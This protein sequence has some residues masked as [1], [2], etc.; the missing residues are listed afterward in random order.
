MSPAAPNLLGASAQ[1]PRLIAHEGEPEWAHVW[2]VTPDGVYQPIAD[3][4]RP[5]RS[6]TGFTQTMPD[7]ALR[8]VCR[9]CLAREAE[10]NEED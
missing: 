6:V 1:V 10:K 5:C 9:E 8:H 4:H 7:G 3:Y 2:A